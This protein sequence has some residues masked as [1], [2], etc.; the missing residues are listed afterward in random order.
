MKRKMILDILPE[1]LGYVRGEGLLA[2][3]SRSPSRSQG[4][5][6]SYR[7]VALY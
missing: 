5:L 7:D 1:T 4:S 6:S 2:R 3:A